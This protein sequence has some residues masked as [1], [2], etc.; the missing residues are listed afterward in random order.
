MTQS[1]MKYEW[2]TIIAYSFVGIFLTATLAGG[3]SYSLIFTYNSKYPIIPRPVVLEPRSGSLSISSEF[4]VFIDNSTSEVLDIAEYFVNKLEYSLGENIEIYNLT[5]T[6]LDSSLILKLTSEEDNMGEEGYQIEI[7]QSNIAITAQK[8]AGLFYGIQTLFQ[9]FP[10][11]IERENGLQVE[12]RISLPCVYI[13]DNPRFS[14]RGMML[15]VGRHFFSVDFIKKYLDLLS[16]YKY[17][18]FH[19]HLTEDQGWR[20][21]I[22]NYSLLT[23]VGAY[24][25]DGNG[26][27][28][29]GYYTQEEIREVVD[30]A[31]ARF[32]TVIPEI[33]MP[34]HSMAA[35][36]AYPNLSCTGGPFNVS[37]EWGVHRD[38]YCAGN[39]ETFTFLE[40]VLTEVMELFP[41]KYIHI[42][43]DECPKTRWEE[44]PKC[45]ARIVDE[46]L[47]NE[48]E[49]QSYF[50]SR[51][52]DFVQSHNRS[53]IGWNEIIE[54]GL[55]GNATVMAWNSWGAAVDAVRLNHNVIMTP[56]QYCYFDYYQGNPFTEPKAIGGLITLSKVYKFE[57]VPSELNDEE[58]QFIIGAQG[59]VW[60][61]YID[62]PEYVEYMSVPRMCALAEVIWTPSSQRNWNH[63][64]IRLSEHFYIL[65]EMNVN[66]RPIYFLS[67]N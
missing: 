64:R 60:T 41:S 20:I 27:I 50:I 7:N 61:E 10:P 57:P 33:E 22:K 29:G 54:G 62:T 43:G 39:E 14:Y 51:I 63:F 21:E 23:E 17:N 16:F 32:I 15:D 55:A 37:N 8:S 26:G 6:P 49:L 65:D 24:R 67:P 66:Y 5:G 40:T 42:G 44:C 25:D 12:E 46:G 48:H 1:K 36:A 47:Q 2:T 52:N 11:S 45:Q 18:T 56:T 58:A 35:L 3:I 9:L 13:E 59:N 31:S 34:G 38:V 19:W 28:Y 4:S 30:Y 53:I